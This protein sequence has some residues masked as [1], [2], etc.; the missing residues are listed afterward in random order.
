MKTEINKTVLTCDCCGVTSEN[1]KIN[2]SF[3]GC[4]AHA[5]W[6]TLSKRM[7]MLGRLGE[8]IEKHFCTFRCL[9]KYINSIESLD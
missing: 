7:G 1:D 3:G 9:T 6:I 4:G 2:I 8:N 5:G